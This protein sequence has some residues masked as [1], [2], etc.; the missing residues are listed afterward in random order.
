MTLNGYYGAHQNVQG[1]VFIN[2]YIPFVVLEIMNRLSN[3]LGV[4]GWYS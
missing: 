3:Y 4:F 1:L 2:P